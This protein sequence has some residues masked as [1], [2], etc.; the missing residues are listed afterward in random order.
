M[1]RFLLFSFLLLGQHAFAQNA[2]VYNVTTLKGVDEVFIINFQN[3]TSV[4]SD[5]EGRFSLASFNI[6]D[7][8]IIQHPSFQTKFVPVQTILAQ[9]GAVYLNEKAVDLG[10]FVVSANKRAVKREDVP[11]KVKV[12]GRKE[13]DFQNPQTSADLLSQSG[14]VFVQKSQLGGGS[15]VIR[16]FA[17]NKVLI[18]VDGVRMNNAIFR[19]GNLQ[20]VLNID[21]ILIEKTEVIFGPGSVI[22]GSDALGGVMNFQTRKPSNFSDSSGFNLGSAMRYSSANNERTIKAYL[23]MGKGKWGSF[24]SFSASAF[25]DLKSGQSYVNSE[26][27]FG[28][29]LWYVERINN[30]DSIIQSSDPHVQRNS[31][32]DQ[33]NFSQKISYKPSDSVSVLYSLIYSSTSDIPRYDRLTETANGLP[34]SAEWYYGPQSWLMNLLNVEINQKRKFF[35]RLNLTVAHQFFEESR[36]DR[37]FNSN[38]L[39]KRTEKVSLI[40][41]NADLDKEINEKNTLF[42]GVEFNRNGVQ[43]EGIRTNVISGASSPVATRYPEAGSRTQQVAAYLSHQLKMSKKS[44]VLWGVR[45]TRNELYADFGGSNF[46]NFSF[47]EV[48]INSDAFTASLGY[49]FRP[50]RVWQFNISLSSG[51]RSPNVDDVA[52]VFD[53]EPGRVVVP[54]ENILPEYAYNGE[55]GLLRK[56][57]DKGQAQVNFFY[58]SLQNTISRSTS[59][60]NGS[61]SI[62]YDGV[63]SQVLSEQNIGQAFVSGVSYSLMYNLNKN[64]G[65]RSSLTYMDG[66][67]LDTKESL[68]HVSPLFGNTAIAF[69][70]EKIRSEFYLNYNGAIPLAE[71]APSEKSK[72]QLY[73][74]NGSLAWYTL[75]LKFSVRPSATTNIT[76]GVE[77][78]LDLHYRPYSSGISAAGRNFFVGFRADI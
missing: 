23:D 26:G 6:E 27:D 12:I 18:V 51:F 5:R 11:N 8:L 56:F 63:L 40:T 65:L 50:W 53:S 30:K 13:I 33:F 38:T 37:K 69:V 10:I 28:K 64:F 70:T 60:V 78:I 32:Y 66:A 47:E 16:G 76:A 22:Y 29:R 35:D 3:S 34:K 49:T 7:T 1:N 25:D 14:E 52:K 4:I 43:S 36:N 48:D 73:G 41:L 77:N 62:M 58:T 2:Q 15:P 68:R 71:L 21:P 57:G 45:Y 24:T 61:D 46:Y 42:Y 31:A 59:Q 54:N 39:R 74:P 20:N 55:I 75:N 72:P 17:A 67:D 9:N 44:T 19:G